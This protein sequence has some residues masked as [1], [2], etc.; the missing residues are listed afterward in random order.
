[1]NYS[2][3]VLGGHPHLSVTEE[4]TA[5]ALV[6]HDRLIYTPSMHSDLG[7][8]VC[9]CVCLHERVFVLYKTKQL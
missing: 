2:F 4:E 6:I 1:M 7:R 9:L 3:S 8:N 5:D